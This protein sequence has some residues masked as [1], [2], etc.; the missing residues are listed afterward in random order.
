MCY[1]V[2]SNAF[3]K[4]SASITSKSQMLGLWYC[5][6]WICG[7]TELKPGKLDYLIQSVTTVSASPGCFQIF[8]IISVNL[9]FHSSFSQL[10]CFYIPSLLCI[11]CVSKNNK[12]S[13]TGSNWE[14]PPLAPYK[15]F[16]SYLKARTISERG[17]RSNATRLHELET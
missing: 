16:Y 7:V 14:K 6:Y 8:L 17:L 12:E 5:K 15:W 10:K 1:F 13:V 9:N 4:V 2:D 3:G 11:V